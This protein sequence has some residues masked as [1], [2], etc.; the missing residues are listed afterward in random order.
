MGSLNGWTLS[1]LFYQCVLLSETLL[2]IGLRR[3]VYKTHDFCAAARFCG[4]TN[5]EV[6][7]KRPALHSTKLHYRHLERTERH[8]LRISNFALS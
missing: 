5:A 6:F 3:S 8:G 4:L 1:F 2:L 7:A